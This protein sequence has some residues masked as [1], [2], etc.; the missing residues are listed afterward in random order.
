MAAYNTA[1]MRR[2]VTELTPVLGL[3]GMPI[4]PSAEGQSKV[5]KRLG[6]STMSS[7]ASSRSITTATATKQATTT[8]WTWDDI[9]TNSTPTYAESQTIKKKTT[10]SRVRHTPFSNLYNRYWAP[11]Y[12][13][14]F[15]TN[16]DAIE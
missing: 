14:S 15:K 5:Y 2:V 3:V 12:S 6:T 1:T 16:S 10:N 8:S 13:Q 11:E 7:F 4:R 9:V